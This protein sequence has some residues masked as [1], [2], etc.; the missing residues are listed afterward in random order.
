MF[1]RRAMAKHDLVADE[2]Q[3]GSQSTS[4]SRKLGG[5][6]CDLCGQTFLW[7]RNVRWWKDKTGQIEDAITYD[8]LWFRGTCAGVNT[9]RRLADGRVGLDILKCTL[10]YQAHCGH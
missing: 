7:R 2:R 1:E 3:Y 6:Q 10:C 5:C 8:Q 4:N 9:G